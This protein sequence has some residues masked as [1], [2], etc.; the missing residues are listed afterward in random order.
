MFTEPEYDN[1][2]ETQFN[3]LDGNDTPESQDMDTANDSPADDSPDLITPEKRSISLPSTCFPLG[4]PLSRLEFILRKQQARRYISALQ[5]V[6]AEKSF[7]YTQIIRHAPRKAVETRAR[8]AIVK[9]NTKIALYAKMYGRCR[10]ALLHLGADEKTLKIFRALTK[11][12]VNASGAIRDPNAPGSTSL[13]LSWIWQMTAAGDETSSHLHECLNLLKFIKHMSNQ[14][15]SSTSAL[16]SCSFTTQSM[17][18][19]DH[20]SSI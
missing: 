8:G 13:R 12:D 15:I 3:D 6:I 2:D 14:F 4:H 11:E 1:N 7:Q 9:L 16:A 20:V 10:A 17:G 5:E 19:R 18:R